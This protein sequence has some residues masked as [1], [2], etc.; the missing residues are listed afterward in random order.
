M[1]TCDD[2]AIFFFTTTILRSQA[3]AVTC[4]CAFYIGTD[5]IKSLFLGGKFSLRNSAAGWMDFIPKSLLQKK[6]LIQLWMMMVSNG[7]QFNSELRWVSLKT[8][9]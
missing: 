7:N 3:Y 5:A 4:I 8:F 2:A 9:R 1:N 6:I